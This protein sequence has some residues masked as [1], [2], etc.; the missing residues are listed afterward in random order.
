MDEEGYEHAVVSEAAYRFYEKGEEDAQKELDEYLEGY[1]IDADYSDDHAVTILRPDG[2]AIVGYRGTDPWNIFDIGAD[3]LILSGYHREKMNL[4]PYTRF[5]RA[6]DHYERVAK[7]YDVSSVT[8]HSLGGSLADFV[9]RRF[10]TPAY[11]FNAGET[12]FEFARFGFVEPSKTKLYTTGDDPI[13]ASGFAYKNHQKI[14]NVPKTVE[15]GYY[16][17]DSH[18]L[19][20]FMPQPKKLKPQ[21]K[22]EVAAPKQDRREER[23]CR[24]YPELCPEGD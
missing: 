20:N 23:L 11:A 10:N 17:L 6:S 21:P 12:P 16:Y 7:E 8:G 24:L 1:T 3:T 13:S 18:S 5:Q 2:S 14:I 19:L 4:L 22:K 9:G 15:G